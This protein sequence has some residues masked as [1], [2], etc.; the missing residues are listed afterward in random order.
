MLHEV[1]LALSGHPSPIFEDTKS[2]PHVTAPEAALL[3]SLGHL[4]KLH[5]ALR[6][7]VTK[8]SAQ[9]PSIICRAV[10]GAIGSQHLARFQ[11]AVLDVERKILDDDPRTVG[12]YKIVPL[13]S[14][15]GDFSGWSRLLEWYW[16]ISCT[17][18]EPEHRGSLQQ[19]SVSV[20]NGP[21]LIN[22]LRKDTM[23]GYSDIENA[24]LGLCRVAESTWLKQLSTFLMW[25]HQPGWDFFVQSETGKQNERFV[26]NASL[27]PNFIS[28]ESANAV[29]GIG[30]TAQ[31]LDNMRHGATTRIY[32]G[33]SHS[34]DKSDRIRHLAKLRH[35]FSREEVS[36]AVQKARNYLSTQLVEGELPPEEVFKIIQQM[37]NFFLLQ[38]VDFTDALIEAAD[39]HLRD[40]H[41]QVQLKATHGHDQDMIGV[42]MREGELSSVLSKTCIMMSAGLGRARSIDTEIEW[43][44][45]NI[46]LKLAQPTVSDESDDNEDKVNKQLRD[47]SSFDEFLLSV[48]TALRLRLRSPLDLLL[49]TNDLDAYSAIHNHLMAIRRA[50]LH[51]TTI[52][53]DTRLRKGSAL[54]PGLKSTY[55]HRLFTSKKL[56]ERFTARDRTMRS[57][58]AT[59]ST[60]IYILHELGQYLISNVIA[61]S[62]QTFTDWLYSEDESMTVK[63]LAE[64]TISNVEGTAEASTI[65]NQGAATSA[66]DRKLTNLNRDP[67]TIS[68]A[69]HQYLY[70]LIDTLML[71]RREYTEAIRTLLL[72]VDHLLGL[73][74]RLQSVQSKLDLAD[75]G[76]D[77]GFSEKHRHEEQD[78]YANLTAARKRTDESLESV[79]STL[80]NIDVDS[81][82]RVDKP[83]L[84]PETGF[85]PWTRGSLE[86]L[87]I[88]LDFTISE[89]NA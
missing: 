65:A 11:T 61:P 9:H 52:W 49:T 12:A 79:T 1:L 16:G 31:Y 39:T 46:E 51:L 88:K 17:M 32:A 67:E 62:W 84:D 41:A 81:V 19:P 45:E 36:A 69:H 80:R 38:R 44:R 56:R 43:A 75:E 57:L 77:D 23:T 42:M 24:A 14:I 72:R 30:K 83:A 26:V 10:A 13:A 8:V 33:Q 4:A 7:H 70:V 28:P 59:S 53:R 55:K 87:L 6:G 47:L 82:T 15:V 89:V 66:K 60:V 2:L 50:H 73:I 22:R 54:S 86:H 20:G 68:Q 25:G 85:E 76:V 71:T 37:K 78:I 63:S 29:L 34:V 3:Q 40:R 35:P 58:W 21:A 27:L 74:H 18:L 5:R 48:P 64:L